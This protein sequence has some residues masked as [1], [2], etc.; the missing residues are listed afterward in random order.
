MQ[1]G[2]DPNGYRTY[3]KE[4]LGDTLTYV[5]KDII[6]VD[7]LYENVDEKNLGRDT[8]YNIMEREDYVL[9]LSSS[10]YPDT[11]QNILM[12][13]YFYDEETVRED[14]VEY[15]AYSKNFNISEYDSW[16]TL[17]SSGSQVVGDV[18]IP[19]ALVGKKV[20]SVEFF[21]SEV[22]TLYIA[23]GATEFVVSFS[24]CTK[25]TDIWLPSTIVTMQ[26]FAF[27][28]NVLNVLPNTVTI[29]CAFS[30]SYANQFSYKWNHIAG[31]T[32]KFNTVYGV[33]TPII[34][35]GIRYVIKNNELIVQGTT[36]NFNGILP[37]EVKL[38]GKVYPVT[39]IEHIDATKEIYIGKNIHTIYENAFVEA[40]ES[41]EVDAENTYFVV[42][43]GVLYNENKDRIVVA[44]KN[45]LEFH[46]GTSIVTIDKN[47]FTN[48]AKAY[49]YTS[50]ESLPSLWQDC[51]FHDVIFILNFK[52]LVSENDFEYIITNANTACLISYKGNQ[53]EVHIDS[54]VQGALLTEVASNAFKDCT[55]LEAVAFPDSIVKFGTSLFEGCTNL[56]KITT[57]YLGTDLDTALSLSSFTG[58]DVYQALESIILTQVKNLADE[59]FKDC[60]SLTELSI[61]DTLEKIGTEM[62]IGCTSLQYFEEDGISYLGNSNNPKVLLV[63]VMDKSITEVTISKDCK[64]ICPD[65]FTGCNQLI[66]VSL[67]IHSLDLFPIKTIT[68]IVLLGGEAID[69]KTLKDYSSIVNLMLPA[70]LKDIEI[71][72]FDTCSNLKNLEIS[73]ENPY[74]SIT[75]GIIYNKNQTEVIGVLIHLET[76]EFA[77]TV[78]QFGSGILKNAKNLKK[79]SI[80]FIGKSINDTENKTFGYLF[81]DNSLVPES[82]TEVAITKEEIIPAGAFSGCK[83]ITKILLPSTL[84]GIERYAFSNCNNL[85]D[86]ELPNTLLSIG[87]RAFAY[88]GFSNLSLP[89]SLTSIG[90][91][92]FIGCA[93]LGSITIPF[94]GGGA[95]SQYMHFGYIF[96][97]N[98][99]SD[100]SK[101]V[102]ASLK[103][104]I[105]TGGLGVTSKAFMGCR[106]LTTIIL[107][108]GMVMIA[109]YAF[110][111][112]NQLTHLSIPD[113]LRSLYMNSSDDGL[114]KC[115]NLVYNEY[116]NGLYL[117]N[118]EN[119]YVIFVKPDRTV[120]TLEIHN[121]T[122]II[123]AY[124][125]IGSTFLSRIIL[126]KSV[127]WIGNSAFDGCTNLSEIFYTGTYE[128]WQKV[129]KGMNNAPLTTAKVNFYSEEE[130]ANSGNYWH[131]VDG[132]PVNW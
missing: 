62:F 22:T 102:P 23:E 91:A 43:D 14:S 127:V 83:Y 16:I 123:H 54:T 44:T 49:I 2:T 89:S 131:Y 118:E 26:D 45:T 11:N 71:G 111:G 39:T 110:S 53:K 69:K 79:I 120:S 92:A 128:E 4:K 74:Y 68:D 12:P 106:N 78:E 105:V 80:P 8:A 84:S 94:I 76:L 25:V 97:A 29:H 99:A 35:N 1:L 87:E 46:V 61:S 40:V 7:V 109:D 5:E 36:S 10:I 130:P 98:K 86:I 19:S 15:K 75:N 28:A 64:V 85:V 121:Q 119:P 59:A 117:G 93:N 67:S 48:C 72:S 37:D 18:T 32:K 116:K 77:D 90:L 81:G 56:K 42:E 52:E 17:S 21:M 125:Y 113:S 108:E 60:A 88:C 6:P 9:M 107:P 96:G 100:N 31:T 58:E 104:V 30:Q 70:T 122:K 66:K 124:A 13:I 41:I 114:D 112:C 82:L 126:P 132:Y 63:D 33:A 65:A 51:D 95:D 55:A 34:E 115:K 73:N 101:S 27:G 129:A 57:P 24:Y 47:A 3:E 38:Y 20:A 103:E 50:Y